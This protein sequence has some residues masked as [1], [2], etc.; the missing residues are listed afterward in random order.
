MERTKDL[1][2]KLIGFVSLVMVMC[3]VFIQS[4]LIVFAA[5]GKIK[6]DAAKVRK[7][8][9]TSS[10]SLGSAV[11]G[12]TFTI[13]DEVTGA[14][15]KV[16]YQIDYEGKT[17]YVRSDLMSKTGEISN[18]Q[19][20]N[21]TV[22]VTDV[23]PVSATIVGSVVRVRSDATTEGSTILASVVDGSVVTITGQA[24]DN[25]DKTWYRVTFSSDSGEVTGFIRQDFLTVSGTITPVENIIVT[26]PANTTPEATPAPETP[27]VREKYYTVEDNG[28]WYLVDRDG[29][30]QYKAVDLIEAAEKNPDIIEDYKAKVKSQKTCVII[31]VILVVAL[32]VGATLLF[33]K[34]RE[35]MDEAY[36][37]A[38]EK[39]TMRQ[40][41]GQKAN[42]PSQGAN[43]KV[44]HTVGAGGNNGN[45]QGAP[46]TS[47]P[48]PAQPR[49]AQ[50]QK[51]AGSVPQT[52]KVSNPTETRTARPAGGQQ[53]RPAGAPA[54]KPIQQRPAGAPVQKPAQ[55]K[56]VQQK[57][58]EKPWN[59]KNF[60][61]DEEDDEFEFEFLNWDGNEDE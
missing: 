9:S 17:G 24:K 11:K 55:P 25:Q 61:A 7:E 38:V 27:V 4:S 53:Q 21:P 33:L 28:T 49:P 52:V 56:P 16:W 30:Y 22:E 20:A 46:K 51:P 15:G 45:R 31:L 47:A 35:V 42:N 58:A 19:T 39:E 10:T 48:K 40:R 41:Q 59:S 34:L 23:Q 14:D 18:N 26:P 13:T 37:A 29:G 32:G 50:G 8:A 44:M 57:P 3:F 2:W 12:T 36:F 54:S 1:R 43:K 5:E 6:V 60:V